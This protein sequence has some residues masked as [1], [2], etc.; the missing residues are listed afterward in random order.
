MFTLTSPCACGIGYQQHP[1]T[2]YCGKIQCY[3]SATGFQANTPISY[4]TS[5]KNYYCN[6]P[7]YNNLNTSNFPSCTSS[8]AL[9]STNDGCAN[10]KITCA[11]NSNLNVTQTS[12]FIGNNQTLN[13]KSGYYPSTIT[14]NC[15]TVYAN[16]AEDNASVPSTGALQNTSGTC[17]SITCTVPASANITQTSVN[18]SATPATSGVTCKSGFTGSPTYTCTTNGASAN[19]TTNC[20]QITCTMPTVNTTLDASDL[21]ARAR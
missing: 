20:T 6:D 18:Y 10:A 7:T 4:S 2:K 3:T 16:R 17:A 19:F 15:I 11:I 12:I 9:S 14:T 1:V 13:C 21:R 8:Q 5:A